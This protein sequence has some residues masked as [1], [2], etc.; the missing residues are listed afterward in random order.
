VGRPGRQTK[1]TLE[2]A[3]LDVVAD[4]GYFSSEE[5]LDCDKAG[6]TVALP[7]PMTS[8]AKAEGRFGKQDFRYVADEDVYLR[9]AGEKLAYVASRFDH[10]GGRQ[11]VTDDDSITTASDKAPNYILFGL[12]WR[13]K[14][15]SNTLN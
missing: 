13:A 14:G 11:R 7:K 4:R 6:I 2:A 5:I 9:P 1:T 8:N 12:A 3:S 15:E 10:F